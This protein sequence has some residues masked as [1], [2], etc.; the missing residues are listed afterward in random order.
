MKL[1]GFPHS[2]CTRTVLMM[3][4]ESGI[5]AAFE[6]VDLSKG[7]H[8]QSAH[9]ARH[10]FGRVPVLEDDGFQLYET[11]AIVRY[12]DGKSASGTL[13]PHDPR[14]RALMDQWMSVDA[15]YFTPAAYTLVLQKIYVPMMGGE[16]DEGQAEQAL[17]QVRIVY[18]AM[19]AQ[20]ERTPYLAGEAFSLADLC[21]VQYTDAVVSAVGESILSDTP[22]VKVW[23]EAA[24]HRPSYRAA[25][26]DRH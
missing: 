19:N 4:S 12:L 3:L 10:P 15:C 24:I 8:K 5:E 11:R 26:P 7:E 9:I 6:S 21:F 20:L 17:D 13:T 25:S 23:R 18:R 1:Y 16:T 22:Y 14:E 2:A